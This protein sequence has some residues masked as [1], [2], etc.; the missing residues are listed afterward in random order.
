MANP[1]AISLADETAATTSGAGD[2][3]DLEDGR[4]AVRL[5][6]DVQALTDGE[7][8]AVYLETSTT[9]TAGWRRAAS[10]TVAKTAAPFDLVAAG[11]RAFVRVTW[12]L[13]GGTATFTVT[14]EGHQLYCEPK[15]LS[16]TAIV[17]GAIGSLSP[18]TLADCCL[19]ATADAETAVGSS[20]ELPLVRWSEDLRG[21]VAARAVYYAMSARGYD[22]TSP[23]DSMITANGGCYYDGRPSAA[24]KYFSDVARGTLKPNGI[25]DQ[26]PETYEGAG[27]VVSGPRRGW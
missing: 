2:A 6:L 20:N 3:T 5:T 24:E 27:V 26:T 22:P 16:R 14:G 25:V 15:D 21:H 23:A 1:L 13:S 12:T 4:S 7:Q 18:S 11:L 17:A 10:F 8:L 19:R 9:G